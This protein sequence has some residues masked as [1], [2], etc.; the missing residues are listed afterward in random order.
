MKIVDVNVIPVA[1]RMKESLR[2]GQMVTSTIGNTLV[3]VLTDEGVVGIGEAGFSVL[4][5]PRIKIIVEEILKPLLINEN[6]FNIENIWEKMFKATHCWGRRGMET[7]AISGID[8][9]LWDIIGKVCGKPLYQLMGGYKKRVRA[10][11]A[12]SLKNS[13]KIAQEC[14]DFIQMGFTAIKLRVGLGLKEDISIVKTAREV[15]GESIEL[16]VDANMAYDY[17]TALKMAE[18]FQKYDIRW[19]EE[20]ILSRSIEQYKQEHLLLSRRIAV[21]LAGGEC[22]LTR[23]EFGEI[24]AKKVFDIIQ[25]DCT[26]VGGISEAKK[27]ANMADIWNVIYV[28]HISCSSGTGVGLA[29]NLHLICATSNAPYVSYDPYETPLKRELL[30]FPLSAKDGYVETPER[31]GLGIELNEEAIKKY[32]L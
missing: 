26:G 16:M 31:P 28:P 10:Y 5:Y 27:I 22:L 13:Q 19:L 24:L 7:Y 8:I 4:F 29:A 11:A 21:P 15:V 14:E 9:A 17:K 25:P 23:Y 6:P 3:K 20:P 1:C 32:S 2:W 18:I 12:P 30:K